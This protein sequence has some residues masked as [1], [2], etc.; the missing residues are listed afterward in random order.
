ML[1]RHDYLLV[2]SWFLLVYEEIIAYRNGID[3]QLMSLLFDVQ[4]G[5]VRR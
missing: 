5:E 3:R 1:S 4:G 2:A